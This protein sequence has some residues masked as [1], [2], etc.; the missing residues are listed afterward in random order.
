[1]SSNSSKTMILTIAGDSVE[2]IREKLKALARE[3]GIGLADPVQMNLPMTATELN[4]RAEQSSKESSERIEE[5]TMPSREK[6]ANAAADVVSKGRGRHKKGCD[7]AKC[8]K[9][10][11]SEDSADMPVNMEEAARS[12]EVVPAAPVFVT[13]DQAVE[14]LKSVNAKCGI[15]TAR[16]ILA[17][18]E[19]KRFSE[20]KEEHLSA[21][22][23]E[24]QDAIAS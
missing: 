4:R 11:E 6:L 3:F 18:F 9:A 8:A 13:K 21:F 19:A 1:M 16:D 15:S 10:H 2:E 12:L 20:L 17:K 22:V 7:C 23:K 24:C 5:A 14:A